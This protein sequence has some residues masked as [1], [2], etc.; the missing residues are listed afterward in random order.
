[1]PKGRRL[2]WVAPSG[3]DG[4]FGIVLDDDAF[5]RKRHGETRIAYRSDADERLLK[6]RHDVTR[7]RES[8]RKVDDLMMGSSSGEFPLSHGCA[9]SHHW[10]GGVGVGN[11]GVTV[12]DILGCLGR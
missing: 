9:N 3:E 5:V 2:L 12:Q 4:P 11:G 7:S 8:V 6:T 1:M 10:C